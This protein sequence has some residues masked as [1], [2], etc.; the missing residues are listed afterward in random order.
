MCNPRYNNVGIDNARSEKQIQIGLLRQDFF[1]G[2]YLKMSSIHVAP[3]FI[4]VWLYISGNQGSWN[5]CCLQL[6]IVFRSCAGGVS[7]VASF[8]TIE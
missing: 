1:L 7:G 4:S 6:K 5:V 8:I 3:Y 2:I